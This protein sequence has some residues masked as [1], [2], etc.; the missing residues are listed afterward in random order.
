MLVMS[1]APIRKVR[2]QNFE[3]LRKEKGWPKKTKTRLK[4]DM[5]N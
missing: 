1:H 2:C 3:E 5:K 4:N